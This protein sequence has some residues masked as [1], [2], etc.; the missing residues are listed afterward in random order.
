VLDVALDVVICAGLLLLAWRAVVAT[1]LFFSVVM[2]MVF[3]LLMALTWARLGSPDLALA[4]AAI[5][6]GITGALLLG[7]C[8][9]ALADR[10]NA[11]PLREPHV[12]RQDASWWL[13]VVLSSAGGIGLAVLMH[14]MVDPP[15]ITRNAAFT[16]AAAHELGNP[17][18]A[19]LLDFRGYDTL[20]EMVVLLLAFLGI[21]TLI[22][23]DRLPDLNP[24]TPLRVPMLEPLLAV[25]TPVLV[26]MGLYVF[27]AGSRA[28][29]GA[30]QAG[31]LLGAL[32][33]L[34][35]LS[36]RLASTDATPIVQRLA[37]GAGLALFAAMACAALWWAPAPLTYPHDFSYALLLVIEFVLMLSIAYT[38]VLLFAIAPGLHRTPP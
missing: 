17:V 22:A 19:V 18:T 6:A 10:A 12:A 24:A 37:L 7:A 29:G 38:L 5:G 31:A 36:G 8:R 16:A 23:G 20:L 28:P 14:S 15:A 25:A 2:F 30:F 3:G 13:A 1:D 33:V 26:M 34:Y 9:S 27:W 21:A 11:G 4:E 35:R 32:G